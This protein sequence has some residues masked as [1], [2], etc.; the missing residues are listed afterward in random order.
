MGPRRARKSKIQ[1]E[2]RRGN[3]SSPLPLLLPPLWSSPRSRQQRS[4]SRIFLFLSLSL[5][6]TLSRKVA[7]SSFEAPL[8]LSSN[9]S[10]FGWLFCPLLEVPRRTW[11]E[12]GGRKRR[13]GGCDEKKWGA[14]EGRKDWFRLKKKLEMPFGS[15]IHAVL[16]PPFLHESK[17]RGK[18]ELSLW[19]VYVVRSTVQYC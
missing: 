1:Q 12:E 17:A 5:S 8:P 3:I 16:L 10:L 4:L 15:F 13:E 18:T 11:A 9:F 14:V 19:T 7:P 2:K 6:L